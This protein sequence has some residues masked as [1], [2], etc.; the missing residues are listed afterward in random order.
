MNHDFSD[1][2]STDYL[3][4]E[5]LRKRIAEAA[6]VLSDETDFALWRIPG[7]DVRFAMG[8]S[9]ESNGRNPVNALLEGS[10]FVLAPFTTDSDSSPVSILRSQKM[11]CGLQ[12]ILGVLL[13]CASDGTHC[14]HHDSFPDHL[15]ALL[16]QDPLPTYV[17][18]FHA[19]RDALR[20][21]RFLKLVLSR[22]LHL[23]CRI[24]PVSV[25]FKACNLYPKAMVSLCRMKKAGTW[26]G[27]SP[28]I[29]LEG[30]GTRWHTMALAGTMPSG[31]MDPWSVK[32][33]RE[34]AYVAEYIRKKLKNL[35]VS[36]LEEQGP[37]T[38]AAGPVQHLR[39]D[40]FFTPLKNVRL[41]DIVQALHPTPA[42]CGLPEQEASAFILQQEGSSR[43]YYSGFLG[44]F[45]ETGRTNL[46]VNLR[47]ME[48]TPEG[49]I[50]HAGGGILP[51][52]ELRS[53]WDE[54]CHK[55]KTMLRLLKPG[56]C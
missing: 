4:E 36:A 54:T 17:K 49:V 35:G 22:T 45:D 34:Q 33:R 43:R 48:F 37:C 53:E 8:S 31:T 38:I 47:C 15:D 56:A 1:N 21:G 41:G 14:L 18:K 27:A 25:F 13:Q 51:A 24:S 55:M 40:F 10:G 20:S 26:L 7:E 11:I 52:S 9:L 29:L 16:N 19:F 6:D 3:R 2:A 50:L 44:P 39:T 5:D 12:N 46:Y 32:N 28:E 23:P 30:D 42:V